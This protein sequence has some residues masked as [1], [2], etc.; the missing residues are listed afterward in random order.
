MSVEQ[1]EKLQALV[2]L[3]DKMSVDP[4]IDIE[5][6]IPGVLVTA[7]GGTGETGGPFIQFSYSADGQSPHIQQM[8]LKQNFLDKTPQDLANLITFSVEQFM[9]EIDA[10]AY[11]A[12]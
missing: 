6:F 3:V 8:P 11:G 9:G 7:E 2:E 5:Y 4:D 12:Q 10:R 1:T